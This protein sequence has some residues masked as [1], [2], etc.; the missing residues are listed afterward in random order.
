MKEEL[1]QLND[2][3]LLQKLKFGISAK[4]EVVGT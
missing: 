4:Y 3:K 1:H 2:T